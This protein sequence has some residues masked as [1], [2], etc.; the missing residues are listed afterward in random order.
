MDNKPEPTMEEDKRDGVE[1][2]RIEMQILFFF[3]REI[4][5]MDR[6]SD[7]IDL[8]AQALLAT[9]FEKI[10]APR[11]TVEGY[12]MGGE[13]KVENVAY[14]KAYRRYR[15]MEAAANRLQKE[16]KGYLDSLRGKFALVDLPDQC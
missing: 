14:L 1:A 15:T 5:R 10:G 11:R 16:S 4:P 3:C 8:E 12:I 2:W 13:D 6:E 9:I 7:D